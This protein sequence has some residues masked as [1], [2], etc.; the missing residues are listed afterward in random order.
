MLGYRQG[1]N[2]CHGCSQTGGGYLH[3]HGQCQLVAG[4]PLGDDLADGHTCQFGSYAED[5]EAQCCHQVAGVRSVNLDDEEVQ[6]EV[7]HHGIGVDVA[8]CIPLYR[9]AHNHQSA[10]EQSGEAYTHSVEDDAAKEQHE[11]E[12]IHESVGSREEAVLVSVPSQAFA[13]HGFQW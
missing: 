3:A 10:A 6:M 2:E 1:K 12:Y 11:Q 13:E 7:L 9:G 8:H 4:E 5:A